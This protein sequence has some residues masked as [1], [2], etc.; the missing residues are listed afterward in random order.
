MSSKILAFALITAFWA[1]PAEAQLW[2][3]EA[4]ETKSSD[5]GD[6]G[7]ADVPGGV[8]EDAS[9]N[10]TSAGDPVIIKGD[11]TNPRPNRLD[12]AGAF[13]YSPYYGTFSGNAL[14]FSFWAV[15]PSLQ[16]GFLPGLNDSFS[17]EAGLYS[18]WAWS[19]ISVIRHY[20]TFMPAVGGRWNFHLTEQWT[21][22]AAARFGVQFGEAGFWPGGTGALGATWQLTPEM[23]L[24]AEMDTRNFVN[25]GVSF[26]Y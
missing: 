14:G 1:L 10:N 23:G 17:L 3:E 5:A 12:L 24:R 20:F 22:H 9:A 15:L 16:K 2:E 7:V 8:P 11:G 26:P 18:E 6:A 19:G 13:G 21:L 4:S 25:L